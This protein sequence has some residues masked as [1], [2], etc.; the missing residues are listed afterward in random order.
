MNIL[1]LKKGVSISDLEKLHRDAQDARTRE[2]AQA[3]YLRAKG[4]TAP[5]I[6][7]SLGRHVDTVRRWIRLF[8]QAGPSGLAYSHSGGRRSKLDG[9]HEHQLACWL[10][11]G[12]PNG[13]RWTLEAL[14]KEL[15]SRYGVRIS[16]QQ[17][18]IKVSKLGLRHLMTRPQSKP[19]SPKP[20]RPPR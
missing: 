7:T 1:D 14:E 16:K 10:R 5:E 4:K 19:R 2:R 20:G 12:R 18:S 15:L 9:Q 11:E 6:A 3:L 17:I 13:E 8:N